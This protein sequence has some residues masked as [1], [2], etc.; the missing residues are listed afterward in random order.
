MD[1][2]PEVYRGLGMPGLAAKAEKRQKAQRGKV[3]RNELYTHPLWQAFRNEWPENARP[4]VAP[5]DAE[6]YLEVIE[7]LVENN[8]TPE[9][10]AA[11]AA[12]RIREGK[13]GYSFVFVPNDIHEI[14]TSSK[15]IKFGVSVDDAFLTPEELAAMTPSPTAYMREKKVANGPA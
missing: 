9:R 8:V 1:I 10:V 12:K 14:P 4:L 3:K 2:D 15:T 13:T 6:R 5:R 7:V 11:L